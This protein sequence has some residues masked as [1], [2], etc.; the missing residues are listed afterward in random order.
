VKSFA[1]W[2]KD[3]ESI[4]SQGDVFGDTTKGSFRRMREFTE[5]GTTWEPNLKRG[6]AGIGSSNGAV[7][8]ISPAG[9]IN[10]GKPER[11]CDIVFPLIFPTHRTD[12]AISAA[13]GQA[14]AVAEALKEGATLQGVVQAAIKGAEF[15]DKLGKEKAY[16][17]PSASVARRIE[18]A[19]ELVDRSSNPMEAAIKIEDYIGSYLPAAETL[20]AVIGIF[21]AC[22]GKP[23]LS[24]QIGAS[25]GGD[26]DTVASAVGAIAGAFSGPSDIP[27]D[28]IRMVEEV[29]KIDLEDY[30]IRLTQLA[31]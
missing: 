1:K 8:R 22:K 25:M 30:A 17:I 18:L 19:V 10:P 21:Y 12:V 27:L 7:M 31:S 20:P 29:N 23:F 16:I 26:T 14:A 11:A 24:M 3:N 6:Y 4:W 9:M 15:G 5:Q 2:A 28:M 13:C